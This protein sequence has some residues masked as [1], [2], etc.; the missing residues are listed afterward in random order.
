M[1]ISHSL[2]IKV[3]LLLLPLYKY[4]LTEQFEPGLYSH[5]CYILK[6]SFDICFTL[7]DQLEIA[8]FLA[9]DHSGISNMLKRISIDSLIVKHAATME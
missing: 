1:T 5:A 6:E 7:K 8:P 4:M 2:E 9:T 3:S